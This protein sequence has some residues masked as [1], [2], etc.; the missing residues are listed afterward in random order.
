MTSR[1]PGEPLIWFSA[2][3]RRSMD[4]KEKAA[5]V[6]A[7]RHLWLTLSDI[8]DKDRVFLLDAPLAP[9]GLF[10]DTV[11]TIV[12]KRRHSSGSCLVTHQLRRLLDGSS[13]SRVPAPGTFTFNHLADAFIQSDLQ[14]R[15]IIEAI[16]PSRE[17]LYTSVMT[18]LS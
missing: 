1:S 15:R 4:K 10:G 9:L 5:M 8:K 7:E 18:S 2:P 3:P 6:A 11:Y 12:D 17:Q 16:R 14:M 13:P